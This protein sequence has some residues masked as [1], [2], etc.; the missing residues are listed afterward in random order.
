VAHDELVDVRRIREEFERAAYA[1][2]LMD[3]MPSC[4]LKAI[5]RSSQVSAGDP[6]LG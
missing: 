1:E 3:G 2:W 5:R 4:G 6:V